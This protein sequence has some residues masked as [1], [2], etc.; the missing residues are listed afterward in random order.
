MLIY[1]I[2][3]FIG[4]SVG[5]CCWRHLNL[6]RKAVAAMHITAMKLYWR[7]LKSDRQKIAKLSN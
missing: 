6:V 3:R 7:Y 5:N 4:E 2:S 1:R